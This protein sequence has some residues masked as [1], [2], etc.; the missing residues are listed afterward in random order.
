MSQPDTSPRTF[1]SHMLKE[2]YEQPDAIRQTI[3]QHIDTAT[4]M[5]RPDRFPWTREEVAAL[6][7]VTI[8]ASG[9][10]VSTTPSA[11]SA[12]SLARRPTRQ[13]RNAPPRKTA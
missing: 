5:V 13:P 1:A 11:P 6:R 2:V 10:T 7:R 9:A 12:H 4:G 8:I 3:R